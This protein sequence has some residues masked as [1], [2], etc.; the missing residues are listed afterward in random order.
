MADEDL[1]LHVHVP[2]C[3]GT[4]VRKWL[5][6]AFPNQHGELYP[7]R[8]TYVFDEPKLRWL[9]IGNPNLRSMS[10]HNIRVFPAVSNGRR[11]R[12]FT[13]LRDPVA[14][15]LSYVTYMKQIIG[16]VDDPV[17][18]SGLP[19]DFAERSSR[20]FTSW[21]LDQERDLPFR[22]SYQTNYFASYGWRERSGRGPVHDDGA[23]PLW[24]RDV[25]EAYRS[26]RLAFAKDVLRSFL[27]VGIVERMGDSLGVVWERAAAI[28]FDL[29]PPSDLG[30]E[31]ET[32]AETD[33]VS[34]IR[35]DDPVGARFLAAIEE[36]RELHAF[37]EQLLDRG[38]RE[39]V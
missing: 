9:N 33:D 13:F 2:K 5:G 16:T 11:M 12:Y 20:E 25:W 28:G 23:Y 14:H 30:H 27:A 6:A 34:W 4:S 22:D 38:L 24:E 1:L 7:V 37:A 35:E 36:D 3:A 31:N 18:R 29:P 39:G 10:T 21:L 8:G 15:Y 32:E 26:E 19:D 17:V